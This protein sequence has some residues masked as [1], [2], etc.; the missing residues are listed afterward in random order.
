VIV[1]KLT[2]NIIRNVR[3]D[4]FVGEVEREQQFY[5]DRGLPLPTSGSDDNL[6]TVRHPHQQQQRVTGDSAVDQDY[7]RYDEQVNIVIDCCCDSEL[8]PLPRKYV[9]FVVSTG[10]QYVV[11]VVAVVAVAAAVAAAA[12]NR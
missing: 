11:V 3:C 7:H 2:G 5:K 4:T 12:V 10:C 6:L 8:Q 9:R 1:C